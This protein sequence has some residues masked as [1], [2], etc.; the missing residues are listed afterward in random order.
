MD[1]ER[2]IEILFDG[3][4]CRRVFWEEGIVWEDLNIEVEF[5]GFE[6]FWNVWINK[7]GF[8]DEMGDKFKI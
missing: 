1:V 4:W 8:I 5:G 3:D 6:V 2:I 7:M